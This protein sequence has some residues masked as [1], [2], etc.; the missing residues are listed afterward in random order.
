VLDITNPQNLRLV[1]QHSTSQAFYQLAVAPDQL[2][3]AAEGQCGVRAFKRVGGGLLEGMFPTL[4][5]PIPLDGAV[6]SCPLAAPF[7]PNAD[8]YYRNP[9]AWGLGWDDQEGA[10]YVASRQRRRWPSLRLGLSALSREGN[11]RG[12]AAVRQRTERMIDTASDA[13]Q[14]RIDVA[15]IQQ[16][17]GPEW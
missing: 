2:L 8:S 17:R 6:D 4:P 5:N 15:V 16:A 1:E 10:L 13:V 12:G 7:D 14:S 9:W 3:F 11:E